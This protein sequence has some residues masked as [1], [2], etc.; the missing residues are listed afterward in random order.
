MTIENQG[1]DRDSKTYQSLFSR[2][3]SSVVVGK[4]IKDISFVGEVNGSSLTGAGFV[5]ALSK[6]ITQATQ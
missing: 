3:I 6:I 5:Q 1:R 2:G 4:K